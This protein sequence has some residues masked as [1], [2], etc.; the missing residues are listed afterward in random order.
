[1]GASHRERRVFSRARPQ[2]GEWTRTGPGRCH[3]QCSCWRQ[4]PTLG[5]QRKTEEPLTPTSV[6][7]LMTPSSVKVLVSTTG[8]PS[9][10]KSVN[11]FWEYKEK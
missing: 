8:N 1:M 11:I 4:Q 2:Q 5:R 7:T 9:A 6:F 3:C 10:C